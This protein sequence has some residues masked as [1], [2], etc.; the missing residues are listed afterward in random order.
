VRDNVGVGV[1][2]LQGGN[3]S[4]DFSWVAET[5]YRKVFHEHLAVTADLQYMRDVDLDG[6]GPEG[7]ILGLR[8][9]TQF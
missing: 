8:L 1:A 2:Y 5:Y 7:F 4:I 3:R 9:V 6:A